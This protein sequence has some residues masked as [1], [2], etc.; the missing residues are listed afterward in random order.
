MISVNLKPGAKRGRAAPS[1]SLGLGGLKDALSRFKD[2]LPALAVLAWVA[3]IGWLGWTWTSNRSALAAG[4]TRLEELRAEH[5][6][7]Q[8]VLEQK[9]LAEA[10][11]DSVL[12]QIRT[13]R[14]IDGERFMWAHV[15]DQVAQALPPF[16]WLVDVSALP[17]NLADTT[18]APPVEVQITGRTVDIQGYTRFMR[19]LE[20]SPWLGDVLTVSAN[21]VVEQGRAVTAFIVKATY[22]AADSSEIRTVPVA[23]SVVR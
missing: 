4:E 12:N 11:R 21:T 20:G 23:E 19:Q 3:A 6:R 15:L 10:A 22:T 16:T 17:P 9:R 14:A 13:I 8:D 2:P 18:A 1:F 5:Q 7:Y